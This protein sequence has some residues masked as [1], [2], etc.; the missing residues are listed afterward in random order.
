VCRGWAQKWAQ[1]SLSVPLAWVKQILG[2]A[3]NIAPTKP[4]KPSPHAAALNAVRFGVPGAGWRRRV[5]TL[6]QFRCRLHE[7]TGRPAALE[8]PAPLRRP[9]GLAGLL[10]PP[11]RGA[12]RANCAR[13]AAPRAPSWFPASFAFATDMTE[14]RDGSV[15]RRSKAS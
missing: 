3:A 4:T 8:N 7:G 6:A 11:P 10:G 1:S 14:Y 15:V 9:A 5:A 13:T 2:L 12:T